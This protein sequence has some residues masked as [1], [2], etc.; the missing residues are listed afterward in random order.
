MSEVKNDNH[1]TNPRLNDSEPLGLITHKRYSRRGF[2]KTGVAVGV[3][4]ATMS[5]GGCAH[6]DQLK[7]AA[8][9]L[10]D[11]QKRNNLN[12]TGFNFTEI[13]HGFSETHL[14][15]QEHQAE[16]LLRWGDPLFEG[17]PKFDLNNQ[18]AESQAQ[19]FGY[20]NDYVGYLSLQPK[21]GQQARALLCVNH[22]Y[23]INGLMFPDYAGFDNITAEQ[24]AVAQTATGNSIVEVVLVDGKWSVNTKSKYNRRIN[25]RDTEMRISGPA[26]SHPR[27][28]TNADPSGTKVYGTM[29]NCAGGLTPWGTYLTC[30]ENINYHFGGELTAGHLEST[31]HKRMNVPS[32]FMNWAKHDPRFDVGNEPN[33]PNRFAWVVEIDPLD[34]SSTPVKRTALGRFK[35]E[36]GENVIAKDGRLVVYMGDDQRFEYLYKFVSRDVVNTQEPRANKDLLDHGT[37]Y[38]A[39][40]VDDGLMQWLPLT[41]DNPAIAAEFET[42]AEVLIEARRAS[43]LLGATPMDRPEDVVPNGDKGKVYVMLTNNARRHDVNVVNPRADNVFGHILE[44]TEMHGDMTATSGNWDILVKCGDPSNPEHDAQWNSDISPNGWFASPDNGVLDPSGR[45]WVTTDQGAKHNLSG[46]NDGLWAMVTEGPER[47]TGKMF[48][49]VPNGAELCG[50]A[51]SDDGETLFVAVQ[52]PGDFPEI[53]KAT[54]AEPSTRWPDFD[55]SMAPRPSLVVIQRKG[56]GRVG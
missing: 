27:M 28:Q 38:V 20:N 24:V 25:S 21:Q 42:Q 4:A 40:F 43:D 13:E 22:E 44:I 45:L 9:E 50:P 56:G 16:V 31:N 1:I 11:D 36:G 53:G 3:T 49:R 26:A 5:M 34:P 35:H 14:V 12:S 39:K 2:L 46:T 23:P 33:E 48:F 18:T 52:H 32:N 8:L 17:A 51:F 54:V 19:Q 15:S 10:T 30:E 6:D 41:L 29:N 37:L 7:S 47:G 55:D